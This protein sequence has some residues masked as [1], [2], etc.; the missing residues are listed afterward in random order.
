MLSRGGGVYERSAKS[1]ELSREACEALGIE[2]VELT[3]AELMTA[4]L[5]APVDL[6]WNGG[7][8]T[9]VKASTEWHAHVGDKANDAI[10]VNASDLRARV[11]GEGGQPR[12]DP[13]GPSRVRPL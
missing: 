2:T 4:I 13:A 1:I 9:Y 11:V 8:G 5:Q 12:R 3:P 6:V 10:R 7:I